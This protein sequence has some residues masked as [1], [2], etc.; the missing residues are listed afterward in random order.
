MNILII[1]VSSKAS[2]GY[3]LAEAFRAQGHMVTCASRS[4]RFGVACDINNP[5]DVSRLLRQTKPNVIIH[6]AGVFSTPQAIGEMNEWRKVRAHMDAKG[7]G[8]LVLANAAIAAK[9]P[10][11]FIVLGGRK[12]SAERGFANYTMG[13]GSL[14]ALVQFLAG[15]GAMQ[16]YFIDLPFVTDSTMHKAF[17]KAT[18]DRPKGVP[19]VRVANAISTILKGKFKSGS[20]VVIGKRGGA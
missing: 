3:Q 19:A 2:I 7:F 10:R 20:R 4:G 14:W 8:A 13:N 11:V 9:E 16:S 12:I 6:A 1:G 17:H 5:R 18:G 15:H